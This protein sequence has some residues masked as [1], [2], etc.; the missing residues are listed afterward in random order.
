MK[1]SNELLNG[2]MAFV[3]I[4]SSLAVI[5]FLNVPGQIEKYY[6]ENFTQNGEQAK[7]EAA[8]WLVYENN[9]IGIK[10]KYPKILGEAETFKI[11]SKDKDAPS[12]LEGE[13]ISIRFDKN[14]SI[15]ISAHT[16]DYKGFIDFGSFTGN[17]N[18]ESEC[19]NSLEYSDKGD[20][21]KIINIDGEKVIWENYF[22]EIECSAS[23]GTK[24]YFNNKNSSIYKGLS[25]L[26]YLDDAGLELHKL[27]NNCTDEKGNKKAFLRAVDVSKGII[28]EKDLSKN[29]LEKIKIIN[30]IINNFK[31]TK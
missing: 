26:F 11:S 28:E 6:K 25:I 16:A 27:Y 20:V 30:K 10:F 14:N 4:A 13:K 8:D 5:L 22:S 31:F 9:E 12:Y 29:D 15:Y 24:I 1:K 2:F 23:F 18:I 7:D 21:C 3:I 17:N 19:K